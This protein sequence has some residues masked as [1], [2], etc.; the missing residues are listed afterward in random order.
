MASILLITPDRASED[1]AKQVLSTA[2]HEI[3]RAGNAEEAA[4]AALTLPIERRRR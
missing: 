3:I 2:G 1:Y 4:S